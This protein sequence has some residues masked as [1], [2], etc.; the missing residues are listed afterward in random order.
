VRVLAG[1]ANG[2]GTLA[3]VLTAALMHSRLFAPVPYDLW[4]DQRALWWAVFALILL[5]LSYAY[6][7]P[8]L[9]G[10]RQGAAGRGVAATVTAFV[11]ISAAQAVL[12]TPLLPRSSSLVVGLT[13]PL[14]S[15][16]SWNLAHDADQWGAARD[17]VFA[18]VANTDDVAG[19]CRDLAASPERPA[20]VVGHVLVDEV[21][22]RPSQ[23]VVVEQFV[24]SGA[25]LL[26]MDAASHAF[27]PIIEQAAEIHRQGSRV[28]TL[29]LFYEEWVGKLPHSE[30]VRVSLLFDVG[31]LHRWR[32]VRAKR[33]VDLAF[34]AAGLIALV[35]IAAIV[36]VL[37][38]VFNPGPLLYR[39]E[40]VGK[41]GRRFTM[42]KLRTMT[43]GGGPSD[44][45]NAALAPVVDGEDD[46]AHEATG[47]GHGTWT[48]NN[49]SRITPL[50]R[51][52]RRSHLD[53]LPQVVNI[54]S[55]DL[56]LVG[57]RPEQPHYVSRLTEKI[58]FFDTRHIVR[59][60]LTG[61][62]QV[63]QGYAGDEA[64]A[65]D[66]LQYDFYYLRRQ[67]IRLDAR[68]IWRTVRGV[69][70]ADGR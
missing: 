21:L 9:A 48:A 41:N 59:P 56:S 60:G 18:V 3:L 16:L 50:G 6:G 62:A 5:A 65:F 63:K 54:L 35:P 27:T 20:T 30:L 2:A 28:R 29:S 37:N 67:G 51:W 68:I 42:V 38:P 33:L 66:K 22:A 26:V 55:G 64:D 49:D 25:N 7:L 44:G 12:A 69:L 13:I 34:A 11:A 57:P 39:Q 19:L 46:A 58:D 10:S 32:Y 40:R 52:L 47:S 61:W 15:V 1:P 8:E 23:P 4:Q 24:E 43:Q 70:S 53:E 36:A 14:W 31:E 17:R 45:E